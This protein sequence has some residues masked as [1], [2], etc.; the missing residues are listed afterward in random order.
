MGGVQQQKQ[1]HLHVRELIL[2][3]I[4][5]LHLVGGAAQGHAA[6]PALQRAHHRIHQGCAHAALTSHAL[7]LRSDKAELWQ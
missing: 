1:R 2:L 5:L 4:L 6:Q 7:V 3:G